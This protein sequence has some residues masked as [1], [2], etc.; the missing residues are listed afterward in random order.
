VQSA[1]SFDCADNAVV[2]VEPEAEAE[3]GPAEDVALLTCSSEAARDFRFDL[4]L[5]TERRRAIW[6]HCGS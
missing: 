2:D 1:G 6:Q 4:G 3:E 5:R